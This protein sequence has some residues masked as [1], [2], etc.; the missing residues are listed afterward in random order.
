MK[1]NIGIIDRVIRVLIALTIVV[2][3]FMEL[4]TGTLGIVLLVAAGIFVITTITGFCGLYTILGIRTCPLKE[5]K[6][7]D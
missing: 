7:E 1:K 3:Y 2:L 6:K 5:A 4:I